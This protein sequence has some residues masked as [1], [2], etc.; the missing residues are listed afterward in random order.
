MTTPLIVLGLDVGDP[1]SLTRWVREGTLPTLASIMDRGVWA[2]TTE[3]PDLINEHSV[4]VSLLSG[5]PMSRHGFYYYRRLKPG[6]YEL[7]TV[8]GR[9]A[10][11]RPFWAHAS[12]KRIAVIDAP[13][14]YPEPGVEGIHLAEWATH[15]PSYPPS[16]SP[17][18][19]LETVQRVFGTQIRI[20][21]ELESSL[22]DDRRIYECAL[23]RLEKK[24][25]LCRKLLE[26]EAFDAV[27]IVFGDSHLA[28]HQF[29]EYRPE[30]RGRRKRDPR[31]VLDAAIPEIFQRIDREMG[32]LIG[33]LPPDSNI[34]IVSSTGMQDHY[35]TTGLIEGFCRALGYQASPP[36]STRARPMN[37]LRKL[38]PE[39]LRYALSR[40][41][42]ESTQQRLMNEKFQTGTDWGRTSAFAIPSFFTSFVRVNLK[43]REP[44]GVVNPGA[45]YEGLLARLTDD[46]HHLT[47]PGSGEPLVREVFPTATLYQGRPPEL[48]PDL[49]VEWMPHARQLDRATHPRAEI[50]AYP[51]EIVR[52]NDHSRSGLVA[53]AGPSI[54]REGALGEVSLLDL[55]PTFLALMGAPTAACMTGTP[56]PVLVDRREG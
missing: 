54:R 47:D 24:G 10:A 25:V 34:C 22:D 36:A 15:H 46:L 51:P 28:T 45:D 29:W 55:A 5:V 3:R 38:L 35:P 14:F 37:M 19:L 43:G 20:P 50:V 16:A 18:A 26:G 41:L 12:G 27:V 42:S 2:R 53:M 30:H 8:T 1:D 52:S 13:H 44:Q 21:E 31:G 49:F 23:T 17:P 7:E 48:L 4:W 33:R 40:R 39:R 11:A 6:T 56:L 9:V 32:S